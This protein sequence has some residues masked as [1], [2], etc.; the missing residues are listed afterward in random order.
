MVE[1]TDEEVGVGSEVCGENGK[2]SH[3]GRPLVDLI[4]LIE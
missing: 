3:G 4:D 2:A 1:V